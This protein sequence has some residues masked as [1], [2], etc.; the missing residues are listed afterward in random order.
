M[1]LYQDSIFNTVDIG[2]QFFRRDQGWVNTKFDAIRGASRNPQVLNTETQ[3]F[4][5]LHILCC[6]FTDA[7]GI[8]FVKL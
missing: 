3:L 4:S 7:F 6:D 5:I 8:D 1:S 2:N